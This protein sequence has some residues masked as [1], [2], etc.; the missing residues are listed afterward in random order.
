M[1]VLV[2]MKKL[3]KRKNSI[4]KVPYELENKPLTVRELI[5]ETV[6]VCVRNYN[7][8]MENQ[9]L[10]TALSLAEM[11]DQAESGKIGFGVNYGDKKADLREAQENALQCF[12][13]GIFRIYLG[14]EE[15]KKPEDLISLEED[16]ELTFIRLTMLSGRMW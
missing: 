4:T 8:R 2:N 16:S 10:L 14:T 9:E 11:E 6:S 3:G 12:E 7:E 13:D 1:Q 15:L 5:M